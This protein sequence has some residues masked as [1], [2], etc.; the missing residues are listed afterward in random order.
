[1]T[2]AYG[3]SQAR[4]RIEAE[5]AYTT[6]TATQDLSRMCNLHHSSRQGQILDLLC[7]AKDRT[8]ILIDTSQIHFSYATKGMPGFFFFNK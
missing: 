2:L 3:V 8:C 5:A 4:G 1:M 6:A 7:E